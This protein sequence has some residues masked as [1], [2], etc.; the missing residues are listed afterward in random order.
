MHISQLSESKYLKRID[1]GENGI[2][3]TI[4]SIEQVD[5]ARPGE[6]AD[7]K[8]IVKWEE[9]AK[10]MVLNKGNAERIARVTGSE[11]TED[12]FGKQ[13]VAYDDPNVEFG[14]KLVGGIRIR[15]PKKKIAAPLAPSI[16]PA[17]AKPVPQSAEDE[18]GDV[19][20]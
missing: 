14:G 3:L 6:E 19:P 13:V 17:T 10:P 8:W 4:E 11:D 16:Q 5:L 1:C 9:D 18:D 7:M 20:F 15:A 2:L 12:W